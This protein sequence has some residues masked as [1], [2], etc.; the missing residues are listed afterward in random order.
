MDPGIKG[1]VANRDG[2]LVFPFGLCEARA[3][4]SARLPSPMQVLDVSANL[5]PHVFALA[6]KIPVA[7]V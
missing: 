1:S 6:D 2:A 7:G 5:C 4:I 3:E